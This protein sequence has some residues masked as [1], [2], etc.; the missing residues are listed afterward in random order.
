[1]IKPI[2][3]V[4]HDEHLSRIHQDLDSCIEHFNQR[5]EFLKKQLDDLRQEADKVAAPI[6]ERVI[7]YLI[8]SKKM[9]SYY[10]P[11]THHLHFDDGAILLCD[12]SHEMIQQIIGQL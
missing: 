9:P 7:A 4:S 8:S 11:K 12:G 10:D 3:I 1:M 2:A 5:R 6:L